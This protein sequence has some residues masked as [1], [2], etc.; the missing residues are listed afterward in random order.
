MF[1]IIALETLSIK[2][3]SVEKGF[4]NLPKYAV[5]YKNYLD[6]LKKARYKSVMRALLNNSNPQV[7][8]FTKE[9]RIKKGYAVKVKSNNITLPDDYYNIDGVKVNINAIVGENG[10]GKSTIIQLILRILNNVSY[11][12]NPGID[13]NSSFP[14]HYA[15]CVYARL[16]F[17]DECGEVWCIEQKDLEIVMYHNTYLK[18]HE[19]WHYSHITHTIIW[20]KK[21]KVDDVKECQKQLKDFFYSIVVDYSAYAL[22]IDDYRSEWANNDETATIEENKIQD[23]DNTL[24]DNHDD[25][26]FV[27]ITS[28]EEKCWISSLFHKNDAYQTPIVINPYRVKGNIDYNREQDLIYER[29]FLLMLDNVGTVTSMLNGKTP[30]K[31]TFVRQDELLPHNRKESIFSTFKIY[32]ILNELGFVKDKDN[33]LIGFDKLCINIIKCW[34]NCFGFRFVENIDELKVSKDNDTIAALNYIVYKTVKCTLNYSKY[35]KY[36]AN[37]VSQTNIDKLVMRLY[38]DM[39]H[40]TAKLRKAIALIIFGHYGTDMIFDGSVNSTCEIPLSVLND[41]INTKLNGQE[42]II[43]ELK[44][45]WPATSPLSV[46][47]FEREKLMMR[48]K[49]VKEELLPAS[50]L[51]CTLWLKTENGGSINFESL[52]SGEKQMINTFGT[53]VYQVH[54]LNSIDNDKIQYHNVNLIFDE[55]ELYFHP[56]YQRKLIANLLKILASMKLGLIKNI[57]ILISTHSPFILSDIPKVNILYL[58]NGLDVSDKIKVNPLGAN[59]ND[60][61]HQS[62]FLKDG[63]MGE[64]VTKK[65]KAI[66]KAIEHGKMKSSDNNV[67]SLI[68]VLGDPFI[69]VNL[70]DAYLGA[71]HKSKDCVDEA[72][73]LKMRLDK[74]RGKK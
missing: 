15:E 44:E 70:M 65:I 29:L 21:D 72:K 23:E 33:N 42:A 26:T 34:E 24:K 36:Q 66:I 38:C 59:V 13:N 53:V 56:N 20:G 37:L 60:I 32:Q 64:Y 74:L 41:L 9:Y 5:P 25:N 57:N 14:L 18:G 67:W 69:K 12:M 61:L 51:K 11:A 31:Y 50:I 68:Q 10:C 17:E 47:D 8:L 19:I 1:R 43:E 27:A 63:F 16:Y 40:I 28:D 55:I 62:F 3:T 58:E 4:D 6:N 46:E 2:G 73:W 48:G 7:F 45:R 35:K 52:S 30:Y 49:W 22:N 71:L 39:T 54:N